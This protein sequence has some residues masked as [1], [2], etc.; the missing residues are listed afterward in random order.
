MATKY[1]LRLRLFLLMSL[2]SF[3]T[4]LGL[5][6][7][8]SQ[9]VLVLIAGITAAVVFSSILTHSLIVQSAH[10]LA[11]T[12]PPTSL[13][14]QLPPSLD[15]PERVLLDRTKAQ[16]LWELFKIEYRTHNQNQALL[17][18]MILIA[19]TLGLHKDV[20]VYQRQLQQADPLLFCKI[21]SRNESLLT[22]ACS[23]STL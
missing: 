15:Q 11:I 20:S 21:S 18:N 14:A 16:K 22:I 17:N 1:Q 19:S 8:A 4:R 3:A 9:R 23:E 12:P 6:L 10:T 2:G 7:A 13:V 5:A